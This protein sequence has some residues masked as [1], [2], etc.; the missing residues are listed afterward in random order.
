MST[1][2]MTLAWESSLSR[3]QTLVL[4]AITDHV[5]DDGEGCWASY[6]RI[7]YKTKYD[8]RQVIRIID[9][10]E[11]AG[12]ITHMGAHPKFGTNIWTV[13]RDKIPMQPPFKQWLKETRAKDPDLQ[14]PVTEE[15]GG[16]NVTPSLVTFSNGEGQNV[17]PKV[18]EMSPN[19]SSVRPLEENRE[20][21]A[22]PT[23][24]PPANGNGKANGTQ[25]S[26]WLS[27]SIVD[28]PNRNH[29]YERGSD[30][31]DEKAKMKP[32]T[33]LEHKV[34]QLCNS[35]YITDNQRAALNKKVFAAYG[36]QLP[37]E[38]PSPEEEWQADPVLYCEYVEMCAKMHRANT[39]KAPGRDALIQ[40]ITRVARPKTGWL[41][42]RDFKVSAEAPLKQ[43]QDKHYY[44]PSKP[45]WD[46]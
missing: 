19:P 11:Q 14:P 28:M 38:Y 32:K 26:D 25:P 5:N 17:T 18:S 4:L 3:P 23:A 21:T 29:L 45:V 16:Q 7:A 34:L 9:Q 2:Y 39:L 20:H 13:N 40:L 24:S 1:K 8:R 31:E 15:G 6:D 33:P 44:D 36:K 42:Y 37:K 10:L 22:V 30:E 46:Q 43:I 35:K 12:I 41:D 27:M